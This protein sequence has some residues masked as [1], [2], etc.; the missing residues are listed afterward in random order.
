MKVFDKVFGTYSERQIKK[1]MPLVE[2]IEALRPK[3][4]ELSDE[5]LANKTKEFRARL[6]KGETLDDLLVEA[7][8]VAREATRRVIN[9]EHFRVQII[10][11]IILH[12]NRIAE[13]KTGEGKTQTDILPVYLNALEGKGVHVVTVNEYLAKRDADWMGAVHKFLGLT[14]GVSLNSMTPQEKQEAYACDI[15]YVTNNE[16]GFDYL[17]DNMATYE[18]DLVLRGLHYAI[19]DEVDSILIDEARTPLIISGQGTKSTSIYSMA[20]MLAKQ[21]HRGKDIEEVGKLD[22]ILGNVQEE[23]GDFIVNE[24]DKIITLTEHGVKEAERFFHIENLADSDNVE[25]QH[26]IITA[27]KANNLMMKDKDY[28]VKDGEIVII[29]EFTGRIMPGRRYSDG[30][31]QAI[32]AKENVKIKRESKT[33]AT[34]T[35]Q[36]F[37]NKY[38]KKAGMT[39]TALTEEQEFKDIYGMD[40]VEIPTNR[41]VARIDLED[42]V[43]ITREEKLEAIVN[44]I[45]ETHQTGQPILVGTVTIEASEELS[46]L[47]KKKGIPHTV[48]NAKFH[49]MEAEIVANAGQYGAVTIATNMAGRGT[50]IKLDEQSRAAGGLK[51]IG[52]ERHESRRIDNQLRGRSGRQGDPGISKFYISLEDDLMRLFGSDR[53]KSMFQSMGVERGQEIKHKFVSSAIEK[54]QKRIELRNFDTR[55]RLLEYDQVMNEQ[56]EIIY[57]ERRRV[58]EGES[59]RD[60][61][62][63]MIT[64]IVESA[65]NHVIGEDQKKEDWDFTELN[66]ILLPIIPLELITPERVKGTRKNELEQ[67]LKGEAVKLYESKEAE[68]PQVEIIRELERIVLLKAI[69]SK[70]MVHIDDMVQLRD[71]IGLVA[72]AQKDPVQE[73]KSEAYAMFEEMTDSIKEQTVT[74][75]MRIR[76]G[77]SMEREQTVKI[78]GTNKDDSLAKA[79][80]KRMEK[81]YPNDPC[82]CG[83]GKKYKQCCGRNA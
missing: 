83:S 39:G 68:F 3:M 41:P 53:Y 64:D 27:L 1:I 47:L 44:D 70:W 69:D 66:Q 59:M 52:T 61:I 23:T 78:T 35:F 50:D 81:V 7:F 49:E 43:Y 5:E 42:S 24:K 4:M 38:D 57:G 79:P 48:L 82:P 75:L 10:G 77:N 73:Y 12:Q 13:M 65:V 16:L 36:N 37:F 8:A 31:H 19:I 63:K 22:L 34:I 71:G 51:V 11:G 28:I 18:K 40:V 60:V 17:R 54:A 56:R 30:L 26:C 33:L 15:T 9:T 72:Y 29:D 55:K 20:D 74:M 2:A 32:E 14:V 76:V 25:I 21:L 80:V 67:Q 46:R 6:E 45:V 62:Y 58:L